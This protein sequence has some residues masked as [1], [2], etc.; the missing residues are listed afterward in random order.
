MLDLI[1]R[2]GLVVLAWCLLTLVALQVRATLR[3]RRR[4]REHPPIPA[5]TISARL[6]PDDAPPI[7]FRNGDRNHTGSGQITPPPAP[8]P[9]QPPQ[10]SGRK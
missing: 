3:A 5:E 8:Q 6:K 9:A 10:P 1:F 7:S 2:L 4:R